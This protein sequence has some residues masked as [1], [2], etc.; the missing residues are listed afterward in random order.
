MMYDES[1]ER[2][3]TNLGEIDISTTVVSDDRQ[4]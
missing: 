2:V 3:F 4:T 1:N